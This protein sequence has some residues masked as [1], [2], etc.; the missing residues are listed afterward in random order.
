M[1]PRQ[2]YDLTPIEV[3][4]DLGELDV[5]LIGVYREGDK[6]AGQRHLYGVAAPRVKY[7]IYYFEVLG[8]SGIFELSSLWFDSKPVV[9]FDIALDTKKRI[10]TD[11]QRYVKLVTYL[12]GL[13]GY[14]EFANEGVAIDEP[15]TVNFVIVDGEVEVDMPKTFRKRVNV[16]YG[17]GDSDNFIMT[18]YPV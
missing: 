11:K 9:I 2:I 12:R 16:D 15:I 14:D 10:V 4:K 6:S 18:N 17:N 13:L 7:K 8:L 5:D 3:S 1:T